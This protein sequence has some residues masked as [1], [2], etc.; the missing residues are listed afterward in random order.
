[1]TQQAEIVVKGA[2]EHNLREVSLVLPRNEL[3]CFTGVSGSGKASWPSIRSMPRATSLHRESLDVRPPVLRSDAQAGCRSDFRP[4][5]LD[6]DSRPSGTNPR[7]TVGTVT[8]ILDFLRVL[9]ARVGTSYCPNCR[10]PIAS[11]TQDQITARLLQLENG[12][13][14]TL[15]APVVRAQKGEH[16]DLFADLLRQGYMRARVNGETISLDDPPRLDR[17]MRHDIE[18]VIDRLE[19]KSSVR[20][21]LAEGVEAA[22]ARGKGLLVAHV[23][24]AE[25][26]SEDW[27]LSSSAACLDCGESFEPPTPQL[28]SFNS[29]QG[30]CLACDGLGDGIPRSEQQLD[31]GKSFEQ[32]C[33]V[34]LGALKELGSLEAARLQGCAA[35]IER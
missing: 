32:G 14:V 13:R 31:P 22:I 20:G 1:M 23:E 33:F 30:M 29:P 2:R 16:R 7:S 10:V 5:P 27:L 18:L 9:Y 35:T 12:T 17:N 15:L 25:Q 8:E 6:F 26:A 4:Q 19:I 11:Q 21:R 24:R 34:H 3:I 28:F